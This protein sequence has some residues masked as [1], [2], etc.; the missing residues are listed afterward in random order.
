[1]LTLETFKVKS[2]H[3]RSQFYKK[4]KMDIDLLE[5]KNDNPIHDNFK[6]QPNT[7]QND[8]VNVILS[9]LI[10]KSIQLFKFRN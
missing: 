10:K 8:H 3:P 6:I 2:L 1:M 4:S 7:I 5:L 9:S